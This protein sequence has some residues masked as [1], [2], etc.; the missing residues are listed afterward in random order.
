MADERASRVEPGI[1]DIVH[2]EAAK[3]YGAE[4]CGVFLPDT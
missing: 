1:L 4:W 3:R 2:I